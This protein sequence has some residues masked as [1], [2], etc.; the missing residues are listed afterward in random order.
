MARKSPIC[1]SEVTPGLEL[2]ESDSVIDGSGQMQLHL[3]SWCKAWP[4]TLATNSP[5]MSNICIFL[6][7]FWLM[8][9]FLFDF[10]CVFFDNALS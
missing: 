6:S 3:V 4:C 2:T 5:H 7:E 10:L 8:A 9:N 1:E